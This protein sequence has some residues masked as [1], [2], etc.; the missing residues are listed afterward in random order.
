MATAFPY[1]QHKRIFA[2]LGL[3]CPGVD[4]RLAG[5]ADNA[6]AVF[7]QRRKLELDFGQGWK[8]MR[9]GRGG[10]GRREPSQSQSHAVPPLPSPFAV[11]V[12]AD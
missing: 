12:G 6:E 5:V 9:E 8:R 2:A 11:G 7:S 4:F 3:S 10:K 1:P